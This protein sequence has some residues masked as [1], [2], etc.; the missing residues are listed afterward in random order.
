[1]S[2]HDA[3]GTGT[4]MSDE[5]AMYRKIARELS[6]RTLRGEYG[7]RLP[8]TGELADE[9]GVARLTMQRVIGVLK[10]EGVVTAAP[11]RGIRPT[12]LMRK[13]TNVIGAV[14]G[15]ATGPLGAKLLRGM[16]GEAAS[17]GLTLALEQYGEAPDRAVHLVELL[18]TEQR[19]DGLV[20]WGNEST[21]PEAAACLKAER[22]PFV[23]A[24][25]AEPELFPDCHTVNG[26]DEGAA[27][28]VMQHLAA[29]GHSRIGFAFSKDDA[30][31][32]HVRHRHGQ[33]R[34]CRQ[35]RGLP[36]HPPIEV[37]LHAS[38]PEGDA[39]ALQQLSELTAVFCD[40]DRAAC[41]IMQLCLTTGIRMPGDLAVAG[42]DNSLSALDM[43]LTSVEQHFEVIGEKAVQ[44]LIDEIEG[45]VEA[46]QHLTVEA[47]LIIRGSS[48][49]PAP[50]DCK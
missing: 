50:H 45:K 44:L 9:Y 2:R 41:K 43:D 49:M 13:R 17:R 14:V 16:Q 12:R 39:K 15:R 20:L 8:T 47:E 21:M 19:V 25:E 18:A 23:L 29:T 36:V 31:T 7:D 5:P 24:V 32:V 10:D 11:R 30:D 1:M 4:D 27:A 42:Y 34:A 40:T 3:V 48:G 28:Q 38:D 35:G 26:A 46:P 37:T 6:E 22:L 33:Y